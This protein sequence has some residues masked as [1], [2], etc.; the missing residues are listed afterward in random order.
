[1][2]IRHDRIYLDASAETTGA[3]L[4]RDGAVRAVGDRA[5]ALRDS[6]ERVVEPEAECLFPGLTDAHCH[7]WGLGRRAGSVDLSDT[8]SWGDVLERLDGVSADDLP[9]GWVL[10]RGWD[11]HRWSGPAPDWRADLDELFPETPVCLHRVD[12]H[13]VAVN[14]EALRRAGIDRRSE[15]ASGGRI[16]RDEKGRATGLLIDDAMDRMLDAVPDPDVDEDRRMFREAARQYL[17]YGITCAHIA[18]ARV[19][20]IRMVES[21]HENGELPIRLYVL[22]EGR[23]DAL[24]ELL[25]EGPRY[26]PEAEFACRGVKFFA[27]GALGSRGALLLG[28][29][30]DGSSG[31]SVTGAEELQRR[32]PELLESGWQVGVHAIGDRAN[33][34]VLDAYE[35]ADR[36]AR[37]A[38]RPR[39][40]HAQMVTDADCQRFGAL[41]AIASI[42][43][44]HMY[45]DA[46]WA[47]EAL[48][49]DQ[50]DR[51]FPWRRL[52]SETTLAAGSDFP[53]EDPNPWHG[54]ATAVSRRAADGDRFRPDQALERSEALAAY[55]TGPARAAHWEDRLGRLRPG[56][57]ADAV[58]LDRDPFRASPEELWETE[59]LAT[60]LDGERVDAAS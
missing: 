59:V 4:V 38:L 43:P 15:A 5:D 22:A 25:D 30:A 24:P 26:G 48:D 12:R 42:Q 46:A 18:R 36:E 50:L 41:S 40:E 16:V 8:D 23:D 27:D 37:E 35:A 52:Q 58:A 31:L 6:G 3:L 34:H 51:L 44:I 10:G 54:L 7:L 33:R 2:L 57:A 19:D 55:T 28:T 14:G 29:Y 53:I 45:S 1:M 17:D 39:V 20:R 9:A 21:L 49:A 11:E 47:D 13:A 32:A 60:W 56:Y